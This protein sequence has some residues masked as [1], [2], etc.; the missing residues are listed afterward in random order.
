MLES[1]VDYK[2]KS[3]G[4]YTYPKEEII[5]QHKPILEPIEPGKPWGKLHSSIRSHVALHH[6]NRREIREEYIPEAM[7][8]RSNVF[9]QI[10]LE[11]SAVSQS[12]LIQKI[13]YENKEFYLGFI[14]DKF[15][16][17]EQKNKHI[18]PRLVKEHISKH[19]QHRGFLIKEGMKV[20]E[21]MVRDAVEAYY[22]KLPELK[23][24]YQSV[25]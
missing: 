24:Q 15:V 19:Q 16:V 20:L 11:N 2:G 5:F 23:Q 1:I 17:Y 21:T 6:G 10:T 9:K 18:I 22:A 25:A 14:N 8:R 12:P 13:R 7:T 3:A 4:F